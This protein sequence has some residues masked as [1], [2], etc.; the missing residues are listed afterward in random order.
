MSKKVSITGCDVGYIKR[1]ESLKKIC[2]YL[3]YQCLKKRRAEKADEYLK[4]TFLK[5]VYL[6]SS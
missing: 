3:L 6:R 4:K 5:C 2:L 1:K